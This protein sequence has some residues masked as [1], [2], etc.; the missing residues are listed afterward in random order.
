MDREPAESCQAQQGEGRERDAV[1]ED[2]DKKTQP[3][4]QP[5][6]RIPLSVC[7]SLSSPSPVVVVVVVCFQ[8][9]RIASSHC[10]NPILV[11][12]VCLCQTISTLL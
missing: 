9:E 1:E 12:C 10:V 4:S 8:C 6:R 2:D 5:N 7:L 3:H 11:S